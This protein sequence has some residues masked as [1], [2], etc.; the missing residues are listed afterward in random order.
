[1]RLLELRLGMDRY[2]GKI[3]TEGYLASA[4]GPLPFW[5]LRTKLEMI[6]LP[7]K[8]MKVPAALLLSNLAVMIWPRR[9]ERIEIATFYNPNYESQNAAGEA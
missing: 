8:L 9:Y 4:S 6:D 5:R 3:R 7:R 2:L 1:M